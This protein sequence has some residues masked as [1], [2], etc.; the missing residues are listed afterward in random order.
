MEFPIKM[1]TIKSECSIVYIEGSKVKISKYNS[2]SISVKILPQQTVQNLMK[3]RVIRAVAAYLKVVRRRKPSSA[4]GTRG[5]RAREGMIPPLV[6][7]VWGASSDDSPL[8]RGV[9]GASPEK[10]FKF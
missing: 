3:G 9:W 1:Q 5:G 10:I 8:F 4:E 2:I 7:G 6:R